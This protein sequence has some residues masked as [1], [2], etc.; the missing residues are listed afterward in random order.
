METLRLVLL[1]V[2]VL[3]LV[4]ATIN[5]IQGRAFKKDLERQTKDNTDNTD[6]TLTGMF[7]YLDTDMNII[8]VEGPKEGLNHNLRPPKDYGAIVHFLMARH[9]VEEFTLLSDLSLDAVMQGY[10]AHKIWFTEDDLMDSI[11]TRY[12]HRLSYVSIEHVCKSSC[13]ESELKGGFHE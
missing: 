5:L 8:K 12:K 6:R 10:K 3:L 7:L 1:A 2:S 11:E 9:E 4:V 13:K